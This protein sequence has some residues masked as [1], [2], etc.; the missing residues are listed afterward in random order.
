MPL[1]ESYP[2]PEL[3]SNQEEKAET[4]EKLLRFLLRERGMIAAFSA[5]Y[6]KKRS[7]VREYMNVR[8]AIP[9]P[10]EVLAL[11]DRLFWTESIE[12]G[13]VS[14]S[15]IPEI[16]E[17]IALWQGDIVRLAADAIVNAANSSLLGCFIPRHTCIDNAIHS[18]AGMQLRDACAKIV[19]SIGREA[20]V[21]EAYLTSAYNLPSGCV[22]HT[23]GPMV[24]RELRNEDRMALRAAYTSCLNLAEENGL[25]S[26]A[27]CCISTGVFNFPRGEAA[28][29][30]VGSVVNW[31]LRHP[32]S[33][34]KVIFNT[35]LAEDTEI[36][37]EIL[38]GI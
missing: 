20:E 21:G 38:G 8:A 11:Q 19:A 31:K 5:S 1:C 23:V 12:R 36:Y 16:K 29:I 34:L 3:L 30:A 4:C 18:A 33:P 13:I 37:R 25:K 7:L 27:F 15:E 9:V 2:R 22:L 10:Q 26:V 14:P 17:G 28:E 6:E 35:Y 32:D 24:G